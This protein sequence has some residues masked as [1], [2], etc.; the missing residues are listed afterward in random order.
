MWPAPRD[1]MCDGKP[2]QRPRQMHVRKKNVHRTVLL[3]RAQSAFAV[4]RFAD[5]KSGV[6]ENLGTGHTQKKFIFHNEDDRNHRRMRPG[7]VGTNVAA[8]CSAGSVASS[9]TG[10]DG[11]MHLVPFALT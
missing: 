10:D 9:W 6:S 1:V 4:V 2:I 3:K 7:T 11:A 8:H 5:A